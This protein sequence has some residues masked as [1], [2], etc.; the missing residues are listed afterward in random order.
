MDVA[1]VDRELF[2]L[3]RSSGR[4]ALRI[5]EALLGLEARGGH[6][7]LGFSTLAAWA[8]E[9]CS[10]SGRWAAD[11]RELARRLSGLPAMRAAFE[12]GEL[13]LSLVDL[14]SRHA[15]AEDELELLETTRAMTVREVRATLREKGE[16]A[17]DTE[18]EAMRKVT[19]TVSQ[20][21]AWA[22]TATE[23]L[24]RHM[25]GD[26]NTSDWVQALLAQGQTSLIDVLEERGDWREVLPE[27]VAEA[28][29]RWLAGVARAEEERAEREARVEKRLPANDVDADEA[30]EPDA[31]PHDVYA[32]EELVRRLCSEDASRDLWLGEMAGKLFALRGWS[33]LGYASETQY[34]RERLGLSRSGV[35]SRIRLARGSRRLE[36]VARAVT[37]GRIGVEAAGLV[38]RVAD[39]ESQAAWIARAE[40]RTYK[41]LRQE[42]QMM[43]VLERLEGTEPLPPTDAQVAAFEAAERDVLSGKALRRALGAGN[44]AGDGSGASDVAAGGEA[45]QMSG[46][47]REEGRAGDVAGGEVRG[48]VELLRAVVN[49]GGAGRRGRVT[50]RW[51]L[52]EDVALQLRQ[53]E[54]AYRDAFGGEGLSFVA[55]LCAS[56]WTTWVESLGL[57][58]KWERV[59]RDCLYRC[60]CP[61]CMHRDVT[62]HHV[63]YR[64][65][66]GGDERENLTAP[67][68]YCH[69]IAIHG[70]LME[71][72]GTAP[73][74][75]RWIIGRR[76]LVVVVGREKLT[77]A[78]G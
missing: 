70:G 10:R 57:S 14:L 43:E 9:R 33:A 13:S 1:A 22:L 20:Q 71:V 61:V 76:P 46:P 34:C 37:D 48:A 75:L 68:M 41:H 60:A 62:A 72:S 63:L 78:A 74:A 25:D 45:V 8:F 58:D 12:R 64:S 51:R 66:G 59:Y 29:A 50:V 17:E 67:C 55:F 65:Q 6:Q 47:A 4:L 16:S 27:E 30:R 5:G 26:G 11:R 19:L 7:A 42:V 40:R 35:W 53:L 23:M 24:I 32:A 52:R 49:E 56:F 73:D 18:P 44:G 15:S 38:V 21:E 3:A 2:R 54:R 39:E 36:E 28:H 69:L 77:R 31:E